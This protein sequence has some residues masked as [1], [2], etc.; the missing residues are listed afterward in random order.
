[1]V[2]KT[3]VQNMSQATLNW[4]KAIKT[5]RAFVLAR[6]KTDKG[7]FEYIK[8]EMFETDQFHDYSSMDAL[9][10]SLTDYPNDRVWETLGDAIDTMGQLITDHFADPWN[11]GP[12]Y[13]APKKLTVPNVE[14]MSL[15]TLNDLL[16]A[17]APEYYA[18]MKQYEKE[19]KAAKLAKRKAKAAAITD[20]RVVELATLYN[21]NTLAGCERAV[22]GFKKHGVFGDDVWFFEMSKEELNALATGADFKAALEAKFTD[23]NVLFDKYIELVTCVKAFTPARSSD[24]W[25]LMS[26]ATGKRRL[27]KAIAAL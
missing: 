14:R 26:D 18:E 10:E 1:M 6:V 17:L 9:Y 4:S 13:V 23:P 16:K 20:K 22:K 25:A 19:L 2:N 8:V 24:M 7:T 15:R 5:L 3:G 21:N 12:G 11:F 27:K